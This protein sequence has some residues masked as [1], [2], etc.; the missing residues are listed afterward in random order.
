MDNFKKQR[1]PVIRDIHDLCGKMPISI[2]ISV[3]D[4]LEAYNKRLLEKN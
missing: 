1:D 4:L 3:R 2:L